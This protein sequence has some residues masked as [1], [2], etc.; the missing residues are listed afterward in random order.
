VDSLHRPS[1]GALHPR[2]ASVPTPAASRL[3]RLAWLCALALA[4]EA[5]HALFS[6]PRLAIR[7]VELRGDQQVC[8]QIA[9]SLHLP[10]GTNF[11]LA[12]TK[13]LARQIA[14][15]PAVRAV[16]VARDF[17]GRLVV[18]V[19]RREPVAVIRSEDQAL[20]VDA[21]GV[22]YE[23][24]NEWAWGL[25]ELVAPHLVGEGRSATSPAA[26]A[27]V[28]KLLGVLRAFGQNPQ[29]KLTRLELHRGEEIT[30]ALESGTEVRLG[31]EHQLATKIRLLDAVLRQIGAD[32]IG[33]LDLSD[34][35]GAY[36]RPTGAQAPGPQLMGQ[37]DPVAPSRLRR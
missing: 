16:R 35:N 26:K 32:R 28:A 5:V 22:I 3:R 36:W 10:P 14:N 17:P 24:R 8:A 6:S 21:Q 18:T 15:I 37:G 4:A 33:T 30:V 20:L 13:R 2:E 34:P 1:L 29:F 7:T 12:P 27:E 11:F 19:E 31:T 9:G 25:P 23:I